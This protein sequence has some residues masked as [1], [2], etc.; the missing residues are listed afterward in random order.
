V[1]A[2]LAA[3]IEALAQAGAT[4]EEVKLDWGYELNEAWWKHW[5]VYLAAF[6]GHVLPQYR[7][8][9]DPAVVKLIE[10]GLAMSAMEF[11][12]LEFIRTE[13]WKQFSP[14]LQR[15]D[16][17]LCPTMAL[18]AVSNDTNDEDYFWTDGDGRFHGFDMTAVLNFVSQCPALSVPSGFTKAGL[19]TATQIVARRFDDLM[20][21]RIG[22]ALESALPWASRRPPL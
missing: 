21:L 17:L 18:P 1:A 14:I 8:K 5:C 22:A 10:T 20:A 19:P 2:N 11:K 4:I 6:F 9:M 13:Q 3:S 16:A 7:A 12:R 15:C